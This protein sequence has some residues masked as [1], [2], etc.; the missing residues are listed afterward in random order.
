METNVNEVPDN[1]DGS[2][3]FSIRSDGCHCSI[4]G[5][6]DGE[7]LSLALSLLYSSI[8]AANVGILLGY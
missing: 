7:V 3:K 5:N 1:R 6:L 8:R 2:R 4:G